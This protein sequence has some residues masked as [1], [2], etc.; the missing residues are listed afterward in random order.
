VPVGSTR[1]SAKPD[2]AA[3]VAGSKSTRSATYPYGRFELDM[4]SRLDLDLSTRA[5][6]VP[7]PRIPDGE[8]AEAPA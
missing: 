2:P 6:K 7:G 1:G 5:A 3:T 8:A 4:S